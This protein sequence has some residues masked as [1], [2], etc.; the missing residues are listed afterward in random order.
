M[1]FSGKL[2][3]LRNIALSLVFIGI[4]IMYVGYAGLSGYLG[5]TIQSVG[6]TFMTITIVIGFL[7]IMGS[8]VMY[9]WIGMLSQKAP[10]VE[11]PSCGKVTKILGKTDECMFCKQ[12]LTFD[13]QY[14]EET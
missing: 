4:I 13:P 2:N 14:A 9:M 10:R 12:T 8:S 1:L 5:S 3:K 7:F 11:C 6:W